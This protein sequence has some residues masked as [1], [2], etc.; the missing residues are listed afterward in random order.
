VG[1]GQD[2]TMCTVAATTNWFLKSTVVPGAAASPAGRT[3]PPSRTVPP[4]SWSVRRGRQSPSGLSPSA[5]DRTDNSC[6]PASQK[7]IINKLNTEQFKW[8]SM[9]ENWVAI[10]YIQEDAFVSST[11]S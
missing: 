10:S 1:K 5:T 4:F 7:Y 8:L 6:C 3:V 11:S 9:E 2:S